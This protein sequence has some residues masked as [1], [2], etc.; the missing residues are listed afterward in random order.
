M[1]EFGPR[2]AWF[3]QREPKGANLL[4]L[5]DPYLASFVM[6]RSEGG[7][8]LRGRGFGGGWAAVILFSKSGGSGMAGPFEGL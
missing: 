6:G 4:V 1:G 3:W 5:R 8:G 2:K 7:E